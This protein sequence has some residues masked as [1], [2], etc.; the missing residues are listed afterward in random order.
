MSWTLFHHQF[1]A[2]AEHNNWTVR[3]KA[4]HLLIILQGQAINTL[5][6]IPMQ[7]GYEGIIEVLKGH[8]WDHQLAMAYHFRLKARFQL[9]DELLQE[10]MVIT[11]QVAH[12]ALVVLP[13]YFIQRETVYAFVD[14]IRD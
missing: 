7:A 6:S 10:F 13:Q 11:E 4:T 2:M 5:H 12:R 3:E 8:Y 1:E 9:I 14:G